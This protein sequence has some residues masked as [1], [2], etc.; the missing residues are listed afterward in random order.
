VNV[1]IV[2]GEEPAFPLTNNMSCDAQFTLTCAAAARVTLS[3]PLPQMTITEDPGVAWNGKATPAGLG[4]PMNNPMAK[5]ARKTTTLKI[6][7]PISTS[8][9]HRRMRPANVNSIHRLKGQ[10]GIHRADGE[11]KILIPN[12]IT[13]FKRRHC[14]Q[15]I[16]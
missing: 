10:G 2:D 13:Q 6:L 12:K 16:F 4:A 15:S 3:G 1:L 8:L 5:A 9:S 14:E 11:S 7:H